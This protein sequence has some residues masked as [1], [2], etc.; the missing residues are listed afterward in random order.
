MLEGGFCAAFWHE[1]DFGFGEVV[2]LLKVLDF[3]EVCLGLDDEFEPG[4]GFVGE[5]AEGV[6]VDSEFFVVAAVGEF[7]GDVPLVYGGVHEVGRDLGAVGLDLESVV[8][9]LG[10]EDLDELSPGG[11]LEE[12]F[13]AGEDDVFA[14]VAGDEVCDF[15]GV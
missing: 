9:V 3:C 1:E 15:L 6:G 12:G 4:V 14:W 8:G 2:G 13:A 10:A 5:V 11:L 7:S